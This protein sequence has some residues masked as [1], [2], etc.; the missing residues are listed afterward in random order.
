M[1]RKR[2]RDALSW[3]AFAR[4]IYLLQDVQLD[5]RRQHVQLSRGQLTYHAIDLPLLLQRVRGGPQ[6]QLSSHGVGNRAQ[7]LSKP[8]LQRF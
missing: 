3:M 6:R 7:G 1:N 4:V 8:T 2:T 5:P